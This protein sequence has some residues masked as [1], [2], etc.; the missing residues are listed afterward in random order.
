MATAA[1]VVG[2]LAMPF[3]FGASMAVGA[4][5]A[6]GA[7]AAENVMNTWEIQKKATEV[8]AQDLNACQELRKKVNSLEQCTK[9]FAVFCR[10]HIDLVLSSELVKDEFGFL[11]DILRRTDLEDFQAVKVEVLPKTALPALLTLLQGDYI[12]YMRGCMEELQRFTR[13]NGDVATIIQHI[14]DALRECPNDEEIQTTV[15]NFV[16]EI[17]VE[18]LSS[19]GFRGSGEATGPQE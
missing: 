18:K 17:F 15:V 13:T 9:D 7:G 11:F 2:A 4:A 6:A 3:T 8:V 12:P 10:D 16:K 5:A 1:L 19:L 14:L